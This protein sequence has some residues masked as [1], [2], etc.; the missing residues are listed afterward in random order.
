MALLY[1]FSYVALESFFLTAD[2]ASVA[3]ATVLGPIY[4]I[5]SGSFIISWFREWLIPI[6]GFVVRPFVPDEIE[7]FLVF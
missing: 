5:M 7:Q 6:A 1:S 4:D 3:A 2:E